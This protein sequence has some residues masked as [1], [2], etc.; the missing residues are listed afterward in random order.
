MLRVADNPPMKPPGVA[1]VADLGGAWWVAHTKSRCEKA[2]AWDLHREGVSYFLP[3]TERQAVWGGR[4][5]EVLLPLFTGYVFFCGDPAARHRA[6]TTDRI[7]Q[8]LPV[9]D[10]D[11]FVR[12]LTAVE[13]AV[14]SGLQLDLFPFATEGRRC[15]VAGGPLAGV[16]GQIARRDD[17]TRLVLEVS[18]LGQGVS[19]AIAA[20][21]LEPLD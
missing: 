6:M 16:E 7:C 21:L 9:R 15:R 19:L 2:L 13:R 8:I 12:Q 3:L 14:A 20:D 10:R 4:R 5:R 18:M 11:K 1:S 17:T